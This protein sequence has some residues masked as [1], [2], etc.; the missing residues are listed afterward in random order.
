ME[1]IAAIISGIF[2]VVAVVAGIVLAERYRRQPAT[3]SG[4]G[5]SPPPDTP[6]P[7]WLALVGLPVLPAIIGFALGYGSQTVLAEWDAGGWNMGSL[8]SFVLVLVTTA[9]FVRDERHKPWRFAI[10]SYQLKIFSLWTAYAAGTLL[11]V[12]YWW[13][14]VVNI[15][16]GWWVSSA[17]IGGLLLKVMDYRRLVTDYRRRFGEQ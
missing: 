9:D 8:L 17:L 1:I 6:P 14:D 12:G 2:S 7:D 4:T 10:A 5:P 3:G 11:A 16:V 13:D 15:S